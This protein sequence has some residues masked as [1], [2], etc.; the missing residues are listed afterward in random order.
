MDRPSRRRRDVELREAE[1]AYLETGSKEHAA[2]VHN[3]MRSGDMTDRDFSNAVIES[4]EKSQD[5]RNE[6]KRLMRKYKL[7]SLDVERDAPEKGS[8]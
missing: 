4:T 1:A 2:W 8:N 6:A 7:D 3:A 5:E